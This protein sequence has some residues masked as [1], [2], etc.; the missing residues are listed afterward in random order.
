MKTIYSVYD[1]IAEMLALLEPEKLL[2]IRA[3]A[4]SQERFNFLSAKSK[5]TGLDAKEKDELDH[6]I[7]LERLFR[8]AKIRADGNMSNPGW[9]N[10]KSF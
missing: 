7:V 1:Q 8:L 6:F 9:V 4:D 5:S 10:I 3:T 2:A